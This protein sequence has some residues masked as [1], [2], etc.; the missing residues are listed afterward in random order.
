[1]CDTIVHCY[2]EGML[3]FAAKGQSFALAC[4]AGLGRA[5][6]LGGALAP[7]PYSSAV[8]LRHFSVLE[9]QNGKQMRY[10]RVERSRHVDRQTAFNVRTCQMN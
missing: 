6:R 10:C 2:E 9:L 7:L 4:C 1:M 5:L 3:A 8:R